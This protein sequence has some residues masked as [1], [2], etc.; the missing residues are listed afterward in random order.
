MYDKSYAFCVIN[1]KT[2]SRQC[3]QLMNPGEQDLLRRVC[4]LGEQSGDGG[5]L[6]TEKGKQEVKTGKRA[7][8][9]TLNTSAFGCRLACIACKCT[10]FA[11]IFGLNLTHK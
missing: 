1:G 11:N 10:K 3:V 2:R 6:R 5:L 9:C 7:F 4:V 8:M